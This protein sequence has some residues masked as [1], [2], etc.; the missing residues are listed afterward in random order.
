MVIRKG[1][2]VPNRRRLDDT[3]ISQLDLE[4]K[5]FNVFVNA[6]KNAYYSDDEKTK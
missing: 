2:C 6:L 1:G 5:E 3:Q 4:L